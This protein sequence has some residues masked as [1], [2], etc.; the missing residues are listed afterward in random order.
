M[1]TMS[2]S[3]MGL[4]LCV[5][6]AASACGDDVSKDDARLG[7]AIAQGFATT[8][9]QQVRS[10]APT[11][12]APEDFSFTQACAGGGDISMTGAFEGSAASFSFQFNACNQGG[13]LFDGSWA[14]GGTVDRVTVVGNLSIKTSQVD[15]SCAFDLAVDSG[16][17][18]TGTACGYNVVELAGQ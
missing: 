15:F 9:A 2:M 16:G 11:T 10:Q 1:N 3:K 8:A 5:A 13:V 14:V 7:Y 12:V 18:I 6:L 17:L 4:G